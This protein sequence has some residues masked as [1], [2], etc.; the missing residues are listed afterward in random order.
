[1]NKF[2]C[3]TRHHSEPRAQPGCDVLDLRQADLVLHG[4]LLP[5]DRVALRHQPVAREDA[6]RM[7]QFPIRW[8]S[9]EER[10]VLAQLAQL[11]EL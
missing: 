9:D 8:F 1:M 5:F 3:T 2:E 11:F 7:M 4:V 6:E 10:T